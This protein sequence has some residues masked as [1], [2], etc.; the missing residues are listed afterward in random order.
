MKFYYAILFSLL[1]IGNIQ[2]Q[3]LTVE[4]NFSTSIRSSAK[5]GI[6]AAYLFHHFMNSN[7]DIDENLKSQMVDGNYDLLRFPG[8][9]IGNYYNFDQN[10]YGMIRSE[11]QA[12]ENTVQCNSSGFYCFLKDESAPRNYIHDFID[13]IDYKQA[14]TGSKTE[15]L[16]VLNILQHFMYNLDQIELL[17]NIQSLEE[18]NQAVIDG[19]ISADFKRRI[20]NNYNAFEILT[21]HENTNV[22]GVEFGNELYFSQEVTTLPY[23]V[24]NSDPFFNLQNAL[25]QIDPRITK[26]ISL[27][28]FYRRIFTAIEE[29]VKMAIPM[30]NINH[31]G[32]MS[33]VHLV[34]N[35]KLR[36]RMM[37]YVDAIVPHFYIQ[38]SGANVTPPNVAGNDNNSNLTTIKSSIFDFFDNKFNMSLD[39]I[40]SYF[41]LPDNGV[42][43]WITEYNAFKNESQN[44][45]WDEWANTYLHGVFINR[46]M[47]EI[48]AGNEA[49]KLVDYAILHGWSGSNNTYEHNLISRLNNGTT[50]NRIAYFT[51]YAADFLKSKHVRKLSGQTYTSQSGI[52]F[53]LEPFYTFNQVS[54]DACPD[55]KLI[56]SMSNLRADEITATFNFSNDSVILDSIAYR[57]LSAKKRGYVA[58]NTASPCGKTS[59]NE[60][61]N[62]FGISTLEET[63]DLSQPI[64]IDG[65]F[66]G[67]I[68]FEIEPFV[69]TCLPLFVNASS[70]NEINIYPNPANRFIQ[71]NNSREKSLLNAEVQLTNNLGQVI[72]SFK[73]TSENQSIDV[74]HLDAGIY[75]LS[76]QKD[77]EKF[78]G[79]FIKL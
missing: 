40:S 74:S 47:E 49:S 28:N 26:L 72:E 79:T 3:S 63:L 73:I 30:A 57:I 32:N 12:F 58:E 64:I 15:V 66:T 39:Q 62:V 29:D 77:G 23:N 55:E 5:H 70:L 45:I 75:Y 27:L 11:V 54:S 34:W 8:G 18:L 50:V 14:I 38:T 2:S 67:T 61:E 42:R 44:N 19:T 16:Y 65:Y 59:F 1:I 78:A 20:L 37:P 53:Y 6:N 17:D 76:T 68:E 69:P 4:S 13:Y 25:D 22:V 51:N 46:F 56:F 31:L 24:T 60:N 33:N 7:Y 41:N 71:L 21:N 35:T 10:G 43:I 36:D 48:V 52:D 9:A